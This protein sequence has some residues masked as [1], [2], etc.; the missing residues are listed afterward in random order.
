MN[1]GEQSL[2]LNPIHILTRTTLALVCMGIAVQLIRFLLGYPTAKGLVPL[3]DLNGEANIPTFFSSFLLITAAFLLWLISRADGERRRPWAYLSLGIL[4]MA[5]D[6][7][8]QFHERLNKPAQL[9][10]GGD[11]SGILR[12]SWIILGVA[13]IALMFLIF[14]SFLRRLPAK[15]RVRFTW[16]GLTYLSGS[17][18]IESINGPI[19]EKCGDLLIYNL[20]LAIEETLEMAGVLLLIQSLILHLAEHHPEVRLVFGPPAAS[21][22]GF[23]DCAPAPGHRP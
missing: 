5:M 16:A 15:T 21:P 11:A 9:L 22:S 13:F 1:L 10:T 23:W 2:R 12:N 17:I 20:T 3:F 7:I 8:A 18:G 19:I 6:E 14:W 4:L